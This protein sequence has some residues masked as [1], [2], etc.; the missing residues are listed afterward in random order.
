LVVAS[1]FER[2]LNETMTWGSLIAVRL[3]GSVRYDNVLPAAAPPNPPNPPKAIAGTAR[4]L[5]ACDLNCLL[6]VGAESV[7]TK[8]ELWT[9]VAE[10]TLEGKK[11]W[12]VWKT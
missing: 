10:V 4:L 1:F 6:M 9:K 12:M 8:R 7:W 3:G 2:F 11:E 5:D